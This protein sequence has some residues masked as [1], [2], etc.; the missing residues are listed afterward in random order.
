MHPQKIMNGI[1]ALTRMSQRFAAQIERW[2]RIEAILKE[3]PQVVEATPGLSELM[4][5]A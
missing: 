1:E 5:A 4:E 2:Q 3:N